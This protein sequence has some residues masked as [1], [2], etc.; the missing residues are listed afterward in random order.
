MAAQ[1]ARLPAEVERE[2]QRA[3]MPARQGQRA[4]MAEE[5]PLQQVQLP[6]L[7]E[8]QPMQPPFLWPQPQINPPHPPGIYL[9]DNPPPPGIQ[10]ANNPAPLAPP[11]DQ[12][13]PQPHNRVRVEIQLQLPAELLPPQNGQ[14]PLQDRRVR[15]LQPWECLN[16]EQRDR[17]QGWVQQPQDNVQPWADAQDPNPPD[18]NG[19]GPRPPYLPPWFPPRP[20][21]D[22][23]LLAPDPPQ[24]PR[25]VQHAL[26]DDDDDVNHA[27]QDPYLDLYHRAQAADPQ[28]PPYA[29]HDHD[30]GWRDQDWQPGPD[31]VQDPYQQDQYG[32]LNPYHHLDQYEPP[33][34]YQNQNQHAPLGWDQ[35]QDHHADHR[36]GNYGQHQQQQQQR[37][38]PKQQQPDAPVNRPANNG[39]DGDDEADE[40]D[41]AL[42]DGEETA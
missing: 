20:R 21:I 29:P 40:V 28:V 3:A 26:P 38:I 25:A 17:D 33:A 10:M 13:F 19:H 39:Q 42:F 24:Y 16:L 23:T 32:P 9:A 18:Q 5:Q 15:L 27:R 11:F 1:V 6:A 34:P 31:H 35:F 7:D 4:Q 37:I 2:E 41:Q 22:P 36:H 30:A 14:Q 8:A 12:P